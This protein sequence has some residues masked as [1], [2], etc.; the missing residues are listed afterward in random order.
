MPDQPR[1]PKRDPWVDAKV[2]PYM[3]EAKRLLKTV[4]EP[5]DLEGHVGVLMR[6]YLMAMAGAAVQLETQ[7]KIAQALAEIER[8]RESRGLDAKSHE[9]EPGKTSFMAVFRRSLMNL[10]N[11]LADD[12]HARMYDVIP[13]WH[14]LV[15]ASKAR[16]ADPYAGTDSD[17]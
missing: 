5:G 17:V 9:P 6:L 3:D 14:V 11:V 12:P 4:S 10:G 16:G 1:Q 15:R 7:K 2:S 13:E 8:D